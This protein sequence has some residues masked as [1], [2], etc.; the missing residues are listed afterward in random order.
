MPADVLTLPVR[1]RQHGYRTCGVGKTDHVG[2]NSLTDFFQGAHY[3]RQQKKVYT[4]NFDLTGKPLSPR[5]EK[6]EVVD[7][8]VDV[9]T[10]A[11]CQFLRRH[12]REPFFLYLAYFA[13]HT[14]VSAW[15][16]ARRASS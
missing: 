14:P 12:H 7:L 8:R 1:L 3:R 9:Q 2:T 16:T 11:A 6:V 5:G 4:A 10:E 15:L 13:P